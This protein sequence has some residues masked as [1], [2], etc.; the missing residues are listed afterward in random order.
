ME[1]VKL[2]MLFDDKTASGFKSVGDNL[3]MTSEKIRKQN[4]LIG[5]HEAVIVSLKKDLVEFGTA[6]RKATTRHEKSGILTEIEITKKNIIDE[7]AA[8]KSLKAELATMSKIKTASPMTDPAYIAKAGMAYGSLN[9][10]VQQVVREL[11]AASMG[12]NMFFLAISNNIPIL[13]DNIKRARLENEALKASGATSVPVWKQ[14]AGS[15]LSWQTLMVVGI[16]L[17]SMYGKEIGAWVKELFTG[18]KALKAMTEA[19]L[20]LITAQKTMMDSLSGGSEFQKAYTSINTLSEALKKAKGNTELEKAALDEYNKSLGVT[21]GKATDVDGALK[22]INSNK[23]AYI[24]AMKSMTFANAFFAKSAEDAVKAMGVGMKNQQQLLRE[25]GNDAKG[26]Y[27]EWKSIDDAIKASEKATNNLRKKFG[28]HVGMQ[29]VDVSQWY[30][31]DYMSYEDAFKKRNELAKKMNDAA[32]GERTRQIGLINKDQDKSLELAKNYYENYTSIFKENDWSTADK[33]PGS[34]D[35][36]GAD[37]KNTPESRLAELRLAAL[38][39][40]KEDEIAMMKEGEAKRKAEAELEYNNRLAEIAKEKAAYEKHV[41]ELQKA[42]IPVTTEEA[43]AYDT[44]STQQQLTAKQK[45]NEKIRQIDQ[46]TANQY[47]AIQDE[48]KMNF[49]SRLN[50]ELADADKYYDELRKKAGSNLALVGEIEAARA[51]D[52]ERI[53]AESALKEISIYEDI[54][55][56]RAE[57]ENK[58]VWL[59]T[60]REEKILKVRLSGAQQRLDKLK[61][62]EKTGAASAAEVEAAKVEVEQLSAALEKMPVNK[63]RELGGYFKSMLQSLSDV[64]GEVGETFSA[65]AGS[66]DNIIT[67]FDK[68]STKMDVVAAGVDSLMQLYSLVANQIEAN[69]EMQEKWNEKTED[70]AQKARLARIELQAYQEANIFGVE[71]PY[72][73]A[74]SGAK[75]YAAAMSELQNSLSAL[76]G[77][78]VQT[79][80]KK[81]VS[82]KNIVNGAAAGAGVGA[83]VGSIIPG[84]GTAV[85]AAIG[86]AIGAIFGATQKK[87]VPVFESLT[88]Q[89]GSILKEGTKTFELNPKILEN[90]SKLDDATKKLVDNWEEIRQKALDAEK[91]MEETFRDLA[92]DIGGSLSKSLADSFRNGDVFAA[93][94]EFGDK[95]TETIEKIIEQM[96]F[97][98]HFK[99]YFDELQKRM[100]DSFYGENADGK[101]VDDIIWFSKVYKEG[102]AAY[103]KD[104]QDAKEELKKQG[105]NAWELDSTRKSASK[106]IAQAS[107]DSVDENNGRLTNIQMILANMESNQAN[108]SVLIFRIFDPINRIATNTDRL[109]K[110]EN[111]MSGVKEGIEKINR[112]G[113]NIKR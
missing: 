92:G 100:H 110:I 3:Q 66:V 79:G 88:S 15:L 50:Q 70:A 68:T 75:E 26:M 45:Y 69:K 18:E 103:N 44:L 56:K 17:L 108:L 106:G 107:Q 4:E 24:E 109:E 73:K 80:T 96:V 62:L 6:Y 48:I 61:E 42:K 94:D 59:A 77:G 14:L 43:T 91:Q 29:D 1:P 76:N 87:V 33:P 46:E 54:A 38:R 7:T 51:K 22:L 49:E 67:A 112:D 39:K 9:M 64:G 19:Q 84:L 105:F 57:I 32:N 83:A 74:I 90:Y 5:R 47:K 60:D 58:Q 8:V 11:P 63:L 13:T 95:V 81:V 99:Q 78:Q 20:G 93:V 53:T 10:S 101:I 12:L 82:G 71:N 89:F 27:K 34:G 98:T 65:M 102:I 21:F 72:A 37:N 52:K 40:M 113:I 23:D 97:A 55:I 111:D 30:N 104:M 85:G 25:G 41:Q 2:E 28:N 31:V 35:K 16:T 36:P 86:G